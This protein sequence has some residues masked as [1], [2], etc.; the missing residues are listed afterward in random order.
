MILHVLHWA[1]LIAPLAPFAYYVLAVYCAW[2]YFRQVRKEAPRDSSSTPP[3]SILKPVRGLDREAYENFASFCRLDYPQYEILFAAS[4]AD[5]PVIPVIERLRREF[6][7]QTIRLLTGVP[8]L[9]ANNK[10]NNLCRL[11]QE[12]RHEL[13][14]ISDSDVRVEPDYLRDVAAPFADPRVGA[15]TAFFRGLTDGSFAAEMDALS[16]P[17]DSAG[18]ALVARKMEG[19]VKF[20]FGWTMATTKR[21]L[22]EIG[23]FEG[24]VNHHSDDFELGNR[25]AARGHRIELMRKP[26]CMVF[27]HET[28]GDL[29]R[30]ELRWAIGLRNVRPWGYVGLA[31]TFG[32][33]WAVLAAAVA[34]SGLLAA[35]YLLAYLVLR[36]AVAWTVGVWGLGDPVTRRSLWL[37]PLRDALTS[38]MWVAGFFFSRIEWR[39]IEYF[40]K[41][42]LL[43]PVTPS[44]D[45]SPGG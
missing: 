25:I 17:S 33:P 9:G 26:V 13:V 10:V 8:Q 2:E 40:V 34:S 19:A 32:L 35:A 24:I 27:P 18:N 11:V 12:A 20:A 21:Q 7:Q 41:K 39:G 1:A 28:L 37:V 45:S 29:L 6:P 43:V 44:R 30:H 42:G 22:A 15:V 36:L 5:D 23:G 4:D 14:A 31:L 16:V 3:V 38:V